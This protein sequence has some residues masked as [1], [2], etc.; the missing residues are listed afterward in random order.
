[1]V[2]FVVRL[3][4]QGTRAHDAS[5]MRIC[6]S[7]SQNLDSSSTKW[8]FSGLCNFPRSGI[9]CTVNLFAM[10]KFWTSSRHFAGPTML[11]VLASVMADI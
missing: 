5:G 10:A 8:R 3:D 7:A 11:T 4:L 2:I 1:M 9:N 6:S